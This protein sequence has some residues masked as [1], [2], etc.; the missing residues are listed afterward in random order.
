MN[1]IL[2]HADGPDIAATFQGEQA[3][4]LKGAGRGD[5]ATGVL[6]PGDRI[7]FRNVQFGTGADHLTARLAAPGAPAGAAC[8]RR[9]WT[10]RT[11]CSR[12]C[13]RYGR[14]AGTADEAAAHGQRRP[15]G[16]RRR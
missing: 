13:C 8:S 11:G 9:A 10:V 3:I 15:E 16:L 6:R 5:T 4:D 2:L 1:E 12:G 7:G 14:L